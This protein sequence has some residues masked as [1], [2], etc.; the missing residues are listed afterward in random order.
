MKKCKKIISAIISAVILAT[1]FTVP[2]L[3][4]GTYKIIEEEMVSNEFFK[5]TEFTVET[6][7]SIEH[8]VINENREVFVNGKN[9]TTITPI[10]STDFGIMPL[11]E[12]WIKAGTT[13][14]RYDLRG[15]TVTAAVGILKKLGKIV[16][17]NALEKSLAAVGAIAG[18][19]ILD[20]VYIRDIRTTYY[21]NIDK[22]GRP[23][24]METHDVS[25]V[26]FGKTILKF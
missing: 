15:L 3:A 16:A 23:E 17:A 8:V 10:Q 4:D 24:M 20:G 13:E 26:V 18:T 19:V 14:Y 5:P 2:V 21:R 25:L 9:I 12:E 7:G 6:N 1:T 22:V 11:T